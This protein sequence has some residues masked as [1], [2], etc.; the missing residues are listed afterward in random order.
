MAERK[1][2]AMFFDID[3]TLVSDITESI[4]ESAIRALQMAKEN[5]HEIFI[6][7]GR[8]L[9]S[10]S[11]GL[12]EIGFDGLLC[13]C[14]TYIIYHDEEILDL[15]IPE[16]RGYELVDEM[17]DCGMTGIAEGNTDIYLPREI[18]KYKDIED[19]RRR[20]APWGLGLKKHLED[21]DY[22]YD[23]LYV[24]SDENSD[25]KRFFDFVKEDM[26]IVD[27]R[28][29]MYEIIQKGYSKATAIEVVREHLGLSMDQIY[30]FGDS[31]NDMEMIQYADHAI[32]MGC[33]D[34]V[35]DPYAEY[36]TDTVEND[37]IYKAMKHYGLI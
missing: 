8:T 33:H 23:K 19:I 13:G 12:I 11:S 3:G 31:S 9:C 26:D 34:K 15:E 20:R 4:P 35:L 17:F 10:V 5:G 32:V 36:V 37:G 21:K 22:R 29:G 25:T 27:R 30:V 24:G 1:K 16:K 6:N 2:A 14:G 18:T 7:T 28:N